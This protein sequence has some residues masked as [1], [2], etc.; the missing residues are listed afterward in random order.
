MHFKQLHIYHYIP[1]SYMYINA[2]QTITYISLY[3]KY[4]NVYQCILNNYIYIII[5]QTFTC[6]S[7]HFKHFHI[8]QY[9][10]AGKRQCIT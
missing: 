5:F 10:V 8:Y 3:S 1:N 6:I 9:Y 4:L 2:F 7:M